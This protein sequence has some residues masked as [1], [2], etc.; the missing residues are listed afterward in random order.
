MPDTRT[1]S[2]PGKQRPIRISVTLSYRYVG[3]ARPVSVRSDDHGYREIASGNGLLPS[4]GDP[5][6]PG[7]A[8]VQ[9]D[10]ARAVTLAYVAI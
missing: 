8:T 6:A 1:E 4:S 7:R 9:G 5:L 2:A 10:F 3:C